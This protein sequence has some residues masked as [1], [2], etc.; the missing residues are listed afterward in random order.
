MPSPRW[1]KVLRDLWGNKL[2][3]LL[4]ALSIAIGVFAIGVITQTFTTVQDELAVEYPKS[5]PAEASLGIDGFDDDLVQVVRHMDGVAYAE[6]RTAVAVKVR[7]AGDQWKQMVLWTIPDFRNINVNK[8]FPQP[9]FVPDPTI[10]AE[11]GV[12]PPPDRGMLVERASFLMPGLMPPGAEIGDKIEIEVSNSKRYNLEL[13]GLAHE[14]GRVPPTFAGAAYGYIT[15]GTLEWLTGT[16]E[17]NELDIIVSQD[18]L[19]QKH[20]TEV[21]QR[22]RNK[23]ETAGHTVSSVSVP[24]PGK[25][26]AAD[27]FA[28]LLLLL[29]ALGLSSLFLSGFLIV[30]TISALMNQQVRQIGMMKAIGARSG[31]IAGMYLVMALIYGIIA[32]VIAVPASAFVATSTTDLLSGF[33]NVDFPSFR[34][35]PQLVMVQAAIAL[36]F[37]LLAAIIPILSGTRKTVREA[38]TDYGISSQASSSRRQVQRGRGTLGTLLPRPLMMSLR[39]TFRRRGRL[40]LTL[41]TLVLGGALFMSVFSVRNAMLVTLEDA[42]NYWKFDVLIGFAR[43]YPTDL[44]QQEVSQVPGITHAETWGYNFVRRVRADDSESADL[45]IFAPPPETQMLFPTMIQGRWLV[46]EDEDAIVVSNGTVTAE[47]DIKVG[48]DLTLKINGKKSVWHVVGVARVI[49]NFGGV[50]TVYANYP[51]YSR[52]TGE[53][54]RATSVQV[55]TDRHDAAFED[56]VQKALEARFKQAGIRSASGI[57]S[58]MIRQQNEVF[59]NIII[60]LLLIMAVLMAMVGGLGLMGTMTLNVLERTREIGVMRAIGASNGAV[61][62]IVVVEGLV[63]GTLSWLLGALVAAPLGQ[64]LSAAL[65][66]LIFQLPLHYVIS[67]DGMIIWLIVVTVISALASVLPAQNASRLTVREVLAYE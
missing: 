3:T 59:F 28:G 7:I 30:N 47:P 56:Q 9:T 32:L 17:M 19:N 16:R 12:W 31:Q 63:I 21:A 25:H 62:Q 53:I 39:N 67:P 24:V 43:A 44:I 46:P 10:G 48:D 14:P 22:V 50:G 1:R 18:R 61:R 49:G 55:M 11:R 45:T 64:L 66:T 33:M 40:A 54:G 5:N 57:T 38:I 37:P 34:I 42:L 26:F 60:V 20:I 52:V 58:G 36:L 29:N 6:G 65:G 27:I 8:V 4:V 51:Y 35:I 13:S 23:I 41:A 2:R 15:P